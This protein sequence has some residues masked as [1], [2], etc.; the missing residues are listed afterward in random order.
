MK[1]E[2]DL[3][4]PAANFL[5]LCMCVC[6]CVRACT[7][8]CLF[9]KTLTPLTQITR[10]CLHKCTELKSL[11]ADDPKSFPEESASYTESD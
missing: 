10:Q 2:L 5:T 3:K 7:Y 8:L 9:L 6:V 1:R 11:F 4:L